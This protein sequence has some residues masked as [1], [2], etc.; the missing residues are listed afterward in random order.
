MGNT[1]DLQTNEPFELGETPEWLQNGDSYINPYLCREQIISG[2]TVEMDLK[3]NIFYINYWKSIKDFAKYFK[4][5]KKNILYFCQL[6]MVMTGLVDQIELKDTNKTKVRKYFDDVDIIGNTIYTK[7]PLKIREG[8]C[9]TN[10][11]IIIEGERYLAATQNC[12][13]EADRWYAT[14]LNQLGQVLSYLLKKSIIFEVVS[15]D[16]DGTDQSGFWTSR[17]KYDPDY[18]ELYRYVLSKDILES[19]KLPEQPKINTNLRSSI[20]FD[21]IMVDNDGVKEAKKL[22]DITYYG[23]DFVTNKDKTLEEIELY[24]N[25]MKPALDYL[26]EKTGKEY[27][28]DITAIMGLSGGVKEKYSVSYYGEK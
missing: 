10:V 23:E 27:N 7:E 13:L 3:K 14:Q 1:L 8:T 12:V 20:M 21:L 26:N 2:D 16:F 11:Y 9:Y 22:L 18:Y 15:G 28:I 17:K 5:T 4:P 19:G 6:C 25:T 24:Y